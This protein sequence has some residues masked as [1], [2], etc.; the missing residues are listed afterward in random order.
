MTRDYRQSVRKRLGID[1]AVAF[2]PGGQREEVGDGVGSC[3]LRIVYGSA[4]DYGIARRI[5]YSSAHGG[6]IDRVGVNLP[7]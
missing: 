3:K 4:H 6:S 2:V 5:P 7:D 1:D